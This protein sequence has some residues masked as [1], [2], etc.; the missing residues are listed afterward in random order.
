MLHTRTLPSGLRILVEELPHTHSISLGAFVGVGS[1]HEDRPICGISHFIEHMLFKGSLKRPN[2][3]LIADAIEGVGGI[4]DAYTSFESTV[5][6]AKVADML[7]PPCLDAKDIEKERRVI[8]EE[9]RATEDA[10]SELI[11]LILD[12]AMG[13][14][15]PLGR[16]IAGDEESVVGLTREQVLAHWR[17]HYNPANMVVSN[18]GNIQADRAVAAIEQ[19]LGALPAGIP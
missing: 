7:L 5:Y 17:T 18:A 8:A 11:H 14:D 2:P 15:Q 9:L 13:G 19:A 10:P 1:G 4:L 16:D 3:R 12:D 6:Y